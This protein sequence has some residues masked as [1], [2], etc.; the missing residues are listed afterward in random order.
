[1]TRNPELAM[2]FDEGAPRAGAAV[3]R[4]GSLGH[5]GGGTSASGAEGTGRIRGA[6]T[7]SAG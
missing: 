5:G 3:L 4:Q 6:G 2:R 1:M 7:G